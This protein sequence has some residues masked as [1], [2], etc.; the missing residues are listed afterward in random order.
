ML[1]VFTDAEESRSRPSIPDRNGRNGGKE[2]KEERFYFSFCPDSTYRFIALD[3][4]DVNSIRDS[5]AGKTEGSESTAEFLS[6]RNP[7]ADKNDSTGMDGLGQRCVCVRAR[8][9]HSVMV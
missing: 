8:V 1:I 3:T 4:Y 6:E 5:E 7:N 9:N 2:N